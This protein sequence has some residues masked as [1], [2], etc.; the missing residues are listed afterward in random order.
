M[1]RHYTNRLICY[2]DSALGNECM[3]VIIT[4]ELVNK[5]HYCLKFVI[6]L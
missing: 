3:L 6:L 1:G 5:K 2:L 4:K